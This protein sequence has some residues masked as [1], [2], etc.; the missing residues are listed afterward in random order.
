KLSV[1]IMNLCEVFLFYK[2][3]LL[4][5]ILLAICFI[6]KLIAYGYVPIELAGHD[7]PTNMILLK[8]QDIDEILGMNWRG[9]LVNILPSTTPDSIARFY[10]VMSREEHATH[11]RICEFWLDQVPFLGHILSAEGLANGSL[12]PWFILFEVFLVWLDIIKLLTIALL[13]KDYDLEENVVTDVG[14]THIKESM[15]VDPTM[16]SL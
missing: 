12:L 4:T 11:L 6:L 15:A 8:G 16:Y 7:Y 13:I 10:L 9:P 5:S 1:L 2:R 3:S 14:I